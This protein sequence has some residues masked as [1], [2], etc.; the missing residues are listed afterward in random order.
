[1]KSWLDEGAE[2]VSGWDDDAYDGAIDA[3]KNDARTNDAELFAEPKSS[4]RDSSA[5]A[6]SASDAR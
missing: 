6:E 5:D 2:F 1:V 3:R 4:P